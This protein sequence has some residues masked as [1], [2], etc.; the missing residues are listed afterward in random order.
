MLVP[1]CKKDLVDDLHQPDQYQVVIHPHHQP[2]G[3]CVRLDRFDLNLLVVL[4][5]LLDEC[6]VT[7]ASRRLNIGQS[8][9]SAALAGLRAFFEEPLQV[10]AGRQFTLT[11]R[12]R[13]LV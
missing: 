1:P 2:Y 9:V 13:D 8:A 11:P 5:A 7:R 3:N 6:N 10:P 4:D 12:R